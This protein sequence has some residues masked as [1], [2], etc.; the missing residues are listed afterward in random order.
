MA[1]WVTQQHGD[2]RVRRPLLHN[3]SIPSIQCNDARECP[4]RL[5]DADQSALVQFLAYPRD[6]EQSD[7]MRDARR[8][9]EELHVEGAE[10][11]RAE[12]QS[13]I[14]LRWALRDEAH[15]AQEVD[16]PEIIVLE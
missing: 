1:V 3:E 13:E 10:A 16:G 4:K 8:D 15:K 5:E 7:D 11:E 14:R 2:E 9:D 12:C 6:S